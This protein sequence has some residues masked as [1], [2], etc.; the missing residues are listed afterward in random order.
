[1]P[2]EAKNDVY[3]SHE[4]KELGAPEWVVLALGGPRGPLSVKN[5]SLL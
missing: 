4:E 3:S 2:G 5:Q 1:M